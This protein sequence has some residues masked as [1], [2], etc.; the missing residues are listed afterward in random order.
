MSYHDRYRLQKKKSDATP[1]H[2][3]AA[4]P[5]LWSSP[6]TCKLCWAQGCCGTRHLLPMNLIPLETL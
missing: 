6:M 1:F 3:A 5:Q 2:S 4:A